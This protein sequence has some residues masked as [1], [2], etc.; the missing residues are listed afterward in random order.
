MFELSITTAY[1]QQIPKFKQ[2]QIKLAKN[3]NKHNW[4]RFILFYFLPK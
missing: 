4:V 2:P 1:N 3:W